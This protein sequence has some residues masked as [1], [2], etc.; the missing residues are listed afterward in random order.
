MF[1]R[2]DRLFNVHGLF[3]WRRSALWFR[4]LFGS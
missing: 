3:R 2:S 1:V 4:L